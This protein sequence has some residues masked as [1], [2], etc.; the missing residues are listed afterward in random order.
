MILKSQQEVEAEAKEYRE[1][2]WAVIPADSPTEALKGY[3]AYRYI[4]KS[5]GLPLVEGH[6]DPQGSVEQ[7]ELFQ[8][9]MFGKPLKA[10]IQVVSAN[11]LAAMLKT[12]T[13]PT[14]CADSP[15][16][17][18]IGFVW[19]YLEDGVA[20]TRRVPLTKLKAAPL[21]IRDE[22]MAARTKLMPAS[23]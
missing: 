19:Y 4:A 3:V 9:Y 5:T 12:A 17:R 15:E 16:R 6:V 20:R 14:A 21:E 1:A 10:D 22:I 11:E 2:G 7:T 8:Y 13:V 18:E 23:K